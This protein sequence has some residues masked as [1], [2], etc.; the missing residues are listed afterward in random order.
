MLHGLFVEAVREVK[1]EVAFISKLDQRDVARS[2]RHSQLF[3]DVT[4]ELFG[5]VPVIRI[6]SVDASAGVDNEY[7]VGDAA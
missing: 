6:V 5:Q 7:D 1:D 3:Y 4:D 2:F